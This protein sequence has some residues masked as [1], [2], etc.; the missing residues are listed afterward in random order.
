MRP[1]PYKRAIGA[2]PADTEH[3][4]NDAMSGKRLP[5]EKTPAWR[6]RLL[7]RTGVYVSEMGLGGLL[8]AQ[9]EQEAAG[10]LRL[11]PPSLR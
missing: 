1:I 7:G 4:M 9:D 6:K 10:A 11:V 5:H 2:G 3:R 8:F